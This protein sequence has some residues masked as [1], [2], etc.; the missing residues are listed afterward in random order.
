MNDANKIAEQAESLRDESLSLPW[1][2]TDT[3]TRAFI[4]FWFGEEQRRSL[5]SLTYL[6]GRKR[7]R[8]RDA[9]RLAIS[10]TIITK[11]PRASLARD[12]SHSRPHRVALTSDYDVVQ[13]FRKA[14]SEIAR[15]MERSQLDGSITVN[16]SDARKLP[17]KIKAPS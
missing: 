13:G 4:S 15:Q 16:R 2:D 7:G 3:E 9:L 11:E 1:I 6:V 5:R 10:K 8:L 14:A 12:T 17:T